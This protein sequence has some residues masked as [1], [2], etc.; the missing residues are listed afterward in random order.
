M[1]PL[2][3]NQTLLDLQETLGIYGVRHAERVN[4]LYAIQQIGS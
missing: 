4:E 1:L 2:L 3:R